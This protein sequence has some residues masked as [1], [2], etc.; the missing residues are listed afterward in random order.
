MKFKYYLRGAGVGIIVTT[1]IFTIALL[2]YQPTLSADEIRKQASK[3][4]MVMQEETASGNA[5]SKQAVKEDSQQPT[6]ILDSKEDSKSE[7]KEDNDVTKEP[8]KDVDSKD[9]TASEEKE[10]VEVTTIRFVVRGGQFSD[11]VSN[12][13]AEK[14]LVPDGEE[15]NKWLMRHHYDQDILP[16]VYYIKSDATFKEIAEILTTEQE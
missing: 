8:E 9:T 1:L 14:G 16:G 11:V 6:D 5:E 12:N 13:L 15:Y 4:G 2:R 7:S 3:L 10:E